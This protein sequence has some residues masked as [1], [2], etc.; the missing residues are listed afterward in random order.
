MYGGPVNN[1][2]INHRQKWTNPKPDFPQDHG[3][4]SNSLLRIVTDP[5]EVVSSTVA[6]T[7]LLTHATGQDDAKSWNS[8]A[9]SPNHSEKPSVVLGAWPE[10]SFP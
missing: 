3:K 2:L 4:V 9:R 6:P 8:I 10:A 5:P 7:H 1:G